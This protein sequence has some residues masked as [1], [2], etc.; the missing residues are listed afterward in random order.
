MIHRARGTPCGLGIIADLQGRSS[1]S[2]IEDALTV[3]MKLEH[4]GAVGGDSKTGDGAGILCR[5][6]DLF[7]RKEM[8]IS[9]DIAPSPRRSLRRKDI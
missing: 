2:I 4:R 9:P 5:I 7:F 8:G 6:P 3:L 1:H